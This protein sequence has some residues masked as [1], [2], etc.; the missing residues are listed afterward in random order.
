M[1][2]DNEFPFPLSGV[3]QTQRHLSVLDKAIDRCHHSVPA[4]CPALA[5]HSRAR[6]EGCLP[7][8]SL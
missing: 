2:G 7:S 6:V 1:P 3:C 5:R 4:S 8:Q